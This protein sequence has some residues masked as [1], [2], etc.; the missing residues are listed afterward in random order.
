MKQVL[1]Q[2]GRMEPHKPFFLPCRENPK[3]FHVA[4][5][6]ESCFGAN[7]LGLDICVQVT[8]PEGCCG[9]LSFMMN[10]ELHS[11]ICNS[12]IYCIA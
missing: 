8:K 2:L 4:C 6:K 1:L 3:Q 5:A 10:T 7:P 11:K 12:K 9:I